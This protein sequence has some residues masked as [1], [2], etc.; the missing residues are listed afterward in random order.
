MWNKFFKKIA[1]HFYL[2]LK[3]FLQFL[4][5]HIFVV[6]RNARNSL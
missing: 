5:L 1:I 6:V 4:Q 2:K 3:F